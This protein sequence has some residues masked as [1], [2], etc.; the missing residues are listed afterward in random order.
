MFCDYF[1]KP[2]SKEK[3]YN[4]TFLLFIS[5]LDKHDKK[6]LNEGQINAR[7]IILISH[8]V[9]CAPDKPSPGCA[10]HPLVRWAIVLGC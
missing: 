6:K 7:E 2:M 10:T 8:G 9:C 1:D 4:K 5:L 3:L